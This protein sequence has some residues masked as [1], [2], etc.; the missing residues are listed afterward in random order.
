MK[1]H[2]RIYKC[3]TLSDN[4]GKR[5]AK[6]GTNIA[7]DNRRS[8]EG[9]MINEKNIKAGTIAIKNYGI[10]KYFGDVF[11]NLVVIFGSTP[12]EKAIIEKA[13]KAVKDE[14]I[15][16]FLQ[17]FINY[18]RKFYKEWRITSDIG[19]V[20]LHFIK[21]YRQVLYIR[22]YQSSI[23]TLFNPPFLKRGV[24]QLGQLRPAVDWLGN[25]PSRVQIPPTP[26]LYFF[27]IYKFFDEF[28]GLL[29]PPKCW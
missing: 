13:R 28:S 22:L 23:S 14:E 21:I 26:F 18:L 6:M 17:S 12:N 15:E 11:E 24:A 4:G 27:A 25:L 16:K 9:K 8:R 19:V 5:F 3:A 20:T 2:F 10:E 1:Y 7:A 29:N